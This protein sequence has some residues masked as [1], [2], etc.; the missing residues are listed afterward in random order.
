M[1]YLILAVGFGFVGLAILGAFLPVLP[2]TPFLLVATACF[3]KSSQRWHRWLLN[4][5]LFGPILHNWHHNRCIPFKAKCIAVLSIALFGG[6]SL[7]Y[8]VPGFYPKLTTGALLAV[9]LGVV[10]SIKTC[11]PQSL[12]KH[13]SGAKKN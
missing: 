12:S 1:R 13:S 5:K 8:A 6:F 7:L 4:N 3:A 10:L 2:T 9:G 11:P